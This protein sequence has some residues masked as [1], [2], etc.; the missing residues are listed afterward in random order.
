METDKKK[1]KICLLVP[2]FSS[3]TP[4]PNRLLKDTQGEGKVGHHS[5]SGGL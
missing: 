5:C 2:V 4:G 3:G 1:K